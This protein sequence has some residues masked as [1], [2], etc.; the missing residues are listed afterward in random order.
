MGAE[1]F[2]GGVGAA[3]FEAETVA[4]SSGVEGTAVGLEEGAAMAETLG[5]GPQD[6]VA[7]VAA[8]GLVVAGGL[9]AI[10][11]AI[12]SMFHHNPPDI[13]PL[14]GKHLSNASA[15]LQDAMMKTSDSKQKGK[16]EIEISE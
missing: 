4:A 16:S 1:A 13:Q 15:H 2:A 3:D 5:G 6:P 9:A 8:V 12:G 14:D 10:G 11:G 7:D